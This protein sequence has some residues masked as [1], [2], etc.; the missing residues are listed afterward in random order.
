MKKLY[1]FLLAV[2]TFFYSQNTS[3]NFIGYNSIYAKSVGKIKGDIKNYISGHS[4]TFGVNLENRDEE[5]IKFLSAK[6][7]KYNLVYL[8]MDQMQNNL[9]G[10][11]YGFGKVYSA[12][13]NVDFR[14]AN[15]GDFDVLFSPTIGI[16]YIT[17][18][19][20]TEPDSYFFG[21]HFNAVFDAGLGI[22]YN[23]TDDYSLT[24]KV[25]FLHFSNGAIQLPNAGVNTLSAT[26]GIQKNLNKTKTE[27]EEK[28]PE[29]NIKKQAV[30]ISV[31]VGQRGKYKIKDAFYRVSITP[32]FSYFINNTLGFKIGLDAVYYDKV[33]NP[34]V[35]DDTVPYWGNSWEHW[36]LGTSLGTEVKMNKI[37]FNANYG[38]YLYLK[39]PT[40]QKTYWKA[41][42]RYYITPKI[43]VE[44]MM[45]AHKFQADFLSFG[46]FARF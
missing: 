1:F 41:G 35:Y 33:Y 15:Y 18:T 43:G 3:E 37:S 34:E 44:S 12:T 19:V 23:F 5:W 16:A 13:A 45:H 4:L 29:Q 42:L 28:K 10:R 7:I 36:R 26:I 25:S 30:E 8:D 9:W 40:N 22:Q 38:Y 14:L 24:S 20:Y 39:G 32:A 17:K 31:G 27:I 6:N 11:N 21:S 2:P 46:A